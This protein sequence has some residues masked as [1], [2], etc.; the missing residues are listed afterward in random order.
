M[1][2]YSYTAQSKMCASLFF[3]NASHLILQ[4]HKLKDS[5]CYMVAI[6]VRVHAYL[7]NIV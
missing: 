2:L 6:A 5:T 1:I 4:I 3:A 7:N